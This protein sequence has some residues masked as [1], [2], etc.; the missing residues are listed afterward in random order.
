MTVST[1]ADKR[2]FSSDE[3]AIIDSVIAELRQY[4]ASGTS[5]YSHE[6]S[7]GWNLV[8][9]GETIPYRTAFISTESIPNEDVE[10]ARQ[11]AIERN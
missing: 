2:V 7:P 5:E 11:L 9:I 6:R 8:E 4:D 10:R 1:G 3:L